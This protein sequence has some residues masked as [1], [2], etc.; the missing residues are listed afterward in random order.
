MFSRGADVSPTRVTDPQSNPTKSGRA[1]LRSGSAELLQSQASIIGPDLVISAQDLLIVS[2]SSL[3]LNGHTEGEVRA[4]DIVV[5]ETGRVTGTLSA[6]SV[7]VHGQ[8]YGSIQAPVVTLAPTAHVNGEIH[9]RS[10]EIARG[11]IF[12]GRASYREDEH[13]L[14]PNLTVP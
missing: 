3:Q 8:V 2:Q 13:E 11:A 12:D 6:Q 1:E 14:L 4:T 5:G 9:H 7:V 10:L